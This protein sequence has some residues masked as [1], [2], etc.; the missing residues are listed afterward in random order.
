MMRPYLTHLR[1][2]AAFGLMVFSLLPA[3]AQGTGEPI[4][5]GVAAPLSD[6]VGILGRQLAAGARV[7]VTKLGDGQRVAVVEADTKCSADGGKQA[8]ESF[9]AMNVTIVVGF[10]CADAI[11][12]A[13]PI[14]AEAGIPTL[15]VGVRAN[16][17]TDRRE[18][19]GFLVWRVAPRSDKEAAAAAN[20]LA[21]RWKA[22]PFGLL[23]D[24]S[25]AARA[26]TDSVRRLLADQGMKPQTIDNYRPAEEKQFGLIRRLERTGVSRFFIAGDR[27]DIATIAR[28]ATEIG[29]ALDIVGGEALFDEASK[30]VP[31]PDGIVAVAPRSHFP[32][33]QDGAPDKGPMDGPQG[34][35]GPA[36]AATQIAVAA[37]GQNRETGWP[38][39]DILGSETFST[40]L[41]AIRFDAKGDS[42]L[43]LYRVF[44]W[45]GNGFV[46]ETGG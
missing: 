20:Y 16:R 6:S 12:A 33:L 19:T 46:D 30:D 7:A 35:F 22:Q 2:F 43:D 27:P 42:D 10:L 1:F 13:L 37:A 41:G 34:Y 26:L 23:E 3:Q 29:L 44:E 45:R 17:L 24:G 8:A 32:E 28:D 18:R 21:G 14:L 4:T 15:D 5:L 39:A 31:L 40:A 36:F 38:I 9:V 11:E 25:I